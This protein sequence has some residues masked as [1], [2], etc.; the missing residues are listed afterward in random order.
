M[1][2]ADHAAMM[3]TEPSPDGKWIARLERELEA[4][5]PPEMS[6]EALEAEQEGERLSHPLVVPP[7][8]F[9]A[10]GG[11]A[12]GA[13]AGAIV[14][15]PPG[16][17]IGALVG[18]AIGFAAGVILER[19]QKAR[20]EHDAQLDRDIGVTEGNLGEASPNQPPSVRGVFSCASLGIRS[21]GG[22]EFADGPIQDLSD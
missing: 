20:R 19:D 15:G 21:G 8:A 14:G 13:V 12:A 4:P 3:D 9:E 2:A 6:S 1:E 17:A 22:G 5:P 11:V 10:L 7:Q 16:A 18:S